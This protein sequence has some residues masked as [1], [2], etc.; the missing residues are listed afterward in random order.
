[1]PE[2]S[3]ASK[4]PLWPVVVQAL[5]LLVV[6]LSTY[7]VVHSLRA[8][9]HL[10]EQK[11]ELENI[12]YGLLDASVWVDEI[13][14]ILEH[15]VQ[16]LDLGPE[17]RAAIKASFSRVLDTLLRE[18]DSYIRQRNAQGDWWQRVQGKF[19]Q[20]LQDLLVDF[21]D[22]RDKAPYYAEQI[23]IELDKPEARAE[24]SAFLRT[25]LE[26]VS[27]STFTA[28]DRTRIEAIELEHDCVEWAYCRGVLLAKVKQHQQHAQWQMAVLLGALFVMLL[29]MTL[30]S[31]Q[32]IWQGLDQGRLGW[33][34]TL[35]GISAV[36][37]A[38]V[39][40]PMLNVEARISELKL[41]LLGERIVF[42]DQVLYFQSKSV[43]DIV[44]L[45]LQDGDLGAALVGVAVMTFSVL[46]PLTKLLAA[47]SLLG[48]QPPAHAPVRRFFA[49]KSA[50]WSMADVMV[51][52]IIMAYLGFDG[53]MDSQLG[54]LNQP[55]SGAEVLTT[56][57]T[58]LQPG[59]LLFFAFCMAGLWSST[60][61]ERRLSRAAKSSLAANV[62]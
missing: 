1:M 50:K 27:Q 31:R 25:A 52:A 57:G 43:L 51:V 5:L 32:G 14:R 40:C 10:R 6:L 55:M 22:I 21:E 18:I 41:E 11:A 9:Q 20:G 12:Q 48:P 60:L 23:L 7:E 33:A 4:P 15:K 8:A 17:N 37:A 36:M 56:N 58:E 38:G 61:L 49:L 59:F 28:V 42:S 13:S 24:L 44:W 34:L 45:M 2:A 30:A 46:F 19:R 35:L 53:L 26:D 16:T 3:V 47:L 29:Q 62:A 54:R 39:L